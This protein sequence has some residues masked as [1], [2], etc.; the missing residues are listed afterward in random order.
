M[1]TGGTGGGNTNN[2]IINTEVTG[3]QA[4]TAKLKATAQAIGQVGDAAQASAPKVD[5][6]K[7]AYVNIAGAFVSLG[8]AR[9]AMDIMK[10]V[11]GAATEIERGMA[12]VQSVARLSNVQLSA[13]EEHLI[14]VSNSTGRTFEQVSSTARALFAQNF[15]QAEVDMLLE[16]LSKLQRVGEV[17]EK[18]STDLVVAL[19]TMGV[20]TSDVTLALDH[21]KHLS[22]ASSLDMKDFIEV[23]TKA[24]PAAR[25]SGQSF[26]EMA[27]TATLLRRGF[28]SGAVEGTGLNTALV[29]LG[30]PKRVKFLKE[31]FNVNVMDEATGVM[32]PFTDLMYDLSLA[33]PNV[34]NG[35]GRLFKEFGPRAG[36]GVMGA[37]IQ[38]FLEGM[39][40]ANGETLKGA[41]LLRQLKKETEGAGGEVN[42]SFNIATNNLP[43]QWQRLTKTMTNL[44][45]IVGKPLI[46]QITKVVKLVADAAETFSNWINKGGH[47]F[48]YVGATVLGF[49]LVIGG[50]VTSITAAVTMFQLFRASITFV[51]TATNA[52][53][54]E[55]LKLVSAQSLLKGGIW[56]IGGRAGAA[57]AVAGAATQSMVTMG[58]GGR[59]AQSGVI[60]TAANVP[61]KVLG[62][63]ATAAALT[64][65]SRLA[66]LGGLASKVGG[67]L[68]RGLPVVGTIV[69]LGSLAYDLY[70]DFGKKDE[71]KAA[72]DAQK[73][74]GE[75][76][77]KGAKGIQSAAQALEASATLMGTVANGF[78]K[79]LQE[80]APTLV[81]DDVLKQIRDAGQLMIKHNAPDQRLIKDATDRFMEVLKYSKAGVE[82][83][84]EQRINM[85]NAMMALQVRASQYAGAGDKEALRVSKGLIGTFKTLGAAFAEPNL[86]AT[87]M[88]EAMTASGSFYDLKN[89]PEGDLAKI[90]DRIENKRRMFQS[91][92]Q[93]LP[94]DVPFEQ[95]VAIAKKAG[96]IYGSSMEQRDKELQMIMLLTDI[97]K[98]NR[99]KG[100][101]T[102][103]VGGQ[104][105]EAVVTDAVA[106]V[107]AGGGGTSQ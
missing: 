83:T 97:A 92:V 38:A 18:Q 77:E 48:K 51:K 74:A 27:R 94:P 75:S 20:A 98:S 31:T 73:K 65:G 59:M 68:L 90:E 67:K 14:N 11:V 81:I 39:K 44:V 69:T 85:Q 5:Q 103:S 17:T 6:A 10:G 84:P 21:M 72:D 50:L 7:N 62:A 91:M 82:I 101:L 76:L 88:T 49:G 47:T 56:G 86:I 106:R 104:D 61:S 4:T 42:E 95:R 80:A 57:A 9:K 13:L 64:G 30:N 107:A 89:V 99:E 46:H 34:S 2:I 54:T 52:L 45:G 96:R 78:D 87:R 36:A 79:S 16:P 71:A 43:E 33:V 70:Q 37:G 22:D 102:L 32:R 19:G 25:L 28:K 8:L 35:V 60:N 58:P 63:G 1:A 66:K 26:G 12:N 53:T 105:I 100:K 93:T 23:L 3:T 24:G 15:K 40:L 29:A 41:D 55:V